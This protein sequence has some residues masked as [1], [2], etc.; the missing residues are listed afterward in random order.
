MNTGPQRLECVLQG[1]GQV[2][3]GRSAEQWS[4]GLCREE[5]YSF[6]PQAS[7]WRAH[8]SGRASVLFNVETA[9]LFNGPGEDEEKDVCPRMLN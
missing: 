1:M 3:V 6:R 4:Q 7:D 5:G 9:I 2:N 8:A